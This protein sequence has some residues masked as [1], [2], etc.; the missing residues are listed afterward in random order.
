MSNGYLPDNVSEAD[1]DRAFPGDCPRE[2]SGKTIFSECG[3]E[4]ECTCYDKYSFLIAILKRYLDGDDYCTGSPK[5][6]DCPTKE[7]IAIEKA[8]YLADMRKEEGW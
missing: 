7:D 6:C 4:D 8:E 5:D 1:F 2:C 3:S